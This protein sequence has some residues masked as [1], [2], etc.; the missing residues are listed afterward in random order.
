MSAMLVITR[1]LTLALGGLA[2][3]WGAMAFPIFWEH[4]P[5]ERVA[6]LIINGHPYKRETLVALLPA[7]E[8]IEAER[9]CRSSALTATAVIRL[10]LIEDATAAADRL[11]M[12]E[13]LQLLPDSIRRAILCSPANP[14]LW[15]ILYWLDTSQNGPQPGQMKLLRM[16]Y[17]S[18]ANEGWVGVRRNRL[19][20]SVFELLPPDL[21]DFAVGEFL[22]LLNSAFFRA[23]EQIFIGP[24]WRVRDRILARM[25][26]VGVGN[27]Q[28]FAR[29]LYVHGFDVDVPGVPQR[30][31]RPWRR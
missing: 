25:D 6:K 13:Q 4:A 12:E 18:G 2:V 30:E 19:A 31:V 23:S 3:V 27:R 7:M 21:A 26:E 29:Q 14:F 16:S 11:M 28:I 10:R 9:L 17:R 22:G 1:L 15:T 24:A 20:F 5:V 8:R